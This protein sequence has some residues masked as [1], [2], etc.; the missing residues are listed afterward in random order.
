VIGI[1]VAIAARPA[2]RALGTSY[3][4]RT[5]LSAIAA[6]L[7]VLIAIPGGRALEARVHVLADYPNNHRDEM[8]EINDTLAKQPPGRK[9][10]GPGAENHWWN[11]LSYVYG[12]TPST[13][14]MGGGGLQASPNYDFLWTQHDPLKVA[15]VFDAPYVVF[16]R[17]SGSR[18]PDGE[19][20]LRTEHYEIRKLPS[21][22]LVAPVF[23]IGVL[24]P[25][26][27][28]DHLGH[29]A[30]LEW[31]KG[32]LPVHDRVLAYVGASEGLFDRPDGTVTRAWHQDSPGD[33][34]DIVAEVEAR[35]PTT[36]VI[37][38]SW[39]PR[40]RAFVDG[41]EVPIRRV[42]PD[43]PAVDVPPG[44][45]QIALRF[46]RPWWTHAAWLAWPG[47][48]L[49]AFVIMRRRDRRRG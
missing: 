38:E 25:G 43:F 4:A 16:Q 3:G 26:Y 17:A 33:A 2:W 48:S 19:I 45:H 34:P 46:E 36:F 5:A 35:A 30:A 14:Q 8:M 18:I 11:L 13:L 47:V 1:A 27:H 24:W 44:K 7:V 9:Q 39:H 20:T 32:E 10:T 41:D 21:G 15:W 28:A 6:A 40:W 37:R 49:L 42:T 29:I 22:G 31:I 12:R 23:V